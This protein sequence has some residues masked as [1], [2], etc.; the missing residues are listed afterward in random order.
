MTNRKKSTIKEI[1]T[2]V[3]SG[4]N[5]A[6]KHMN[7]PILPNPVMDPA[8]ARDTSID[9][10]FTPKDLNELVIGVSTLLRSVPPE[11]VGPVYNGIKQVIRAQAE[12]AL[13][14]NSTMITNKK[15]GEDSMNDKNKQAVAEATL[16]HVIRGIIKEGPL[17]AKKFLDLGTEP[18]NDFDDEPVS[19]VRS[20]VGFDDEEEE[21]SDDEPGGLAAFAARLDAE[22]PQDKLDKDG[23][24]RKWSVSGAKQ[25][26]D[27]S[28][29]KLGFMSKLQAQDPERFD[30]YMAQ[31]TDE[32][33]QHLQDEAGAKD[34]AGNYGDITPDD[35]K[36][37]RKNPLALQQSDE[38]RTW[39]HNYV[40]EMGYN[41][42]T[43]YEVED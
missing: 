26:I 1:G 2:N 33:I 41:S 16:R 21:T 4:D 19:G 6:Y 20:K 8:A 36:F 18:D 15:G 3:L 14:A 31:W 32:Y 9:E 27:K 22:L 24:P 43:D 39:L 7:G 28:V 29:R 35:I 37:L 25:A 5:I 11:S 17:A 38:F 23:N 30:R 12:N 42:G 40:R 34:A 13:K 10:D